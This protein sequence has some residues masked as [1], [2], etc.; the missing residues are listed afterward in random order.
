MK[1]QDH[2][3]KTK[4]LLKRYGIRSFNKKTYFTISPDNHNRQKKS[5]ENIVFPLRDQSL[6]K[7]ILEN[8]M[9]PF[10][11]LTFV[12]A[13]VLVIIYFINREE[14]QH[15]LVFIF[16]SAIILFK[17]CFEVY[18]EVRINAF[19]KANIDSF[20]VRVIRNSKILEI[21]KKDLKVGDIL[22]LQKG[23]VV[24]ADSIL[25]SE[26]N[27][28][29]D[30]RSLTGKP[31]L[32]KKHAG[33]SKA[34]FEH[35]ENVVLNG[36]KV[37]TGRGKA[38]VVRIGKNTVLGKSYS[39]LSLR[40]INESILNTEIR[41]YFYGSMIFST[42]LSVL[43]IIPAVLYH[44]SFLNMLSLII[45]VYVAVIPE[46]IVSIAKLMLFSAISKLDQRGITIRDVNAIEKLGLLT[47]VL[48]EKQT[49]INLNCKICDYIY[50]GDSLIDIDL[51]FQDNDDKSLKSIEYFGR[52]SYLI[53][54]KTN[55]I[56]KPVHQASFKL[57]GELCNKYFVGVSRVSTK[58]KDKKI[59]NVIASIV[60]N[61]DFKSVYV[62][63][64]LDSVIK[65]CNK[66]RKDGKVQHL[67]REIKNKIYRNCQK[68]KLNGSDIIVMAGR[69]YKSDEPEIKLKGLIFECAFFFEE[70]P[71]VSIYASVEV[72]KASGIK[73]SILTDSIYESDLKSCKKVLGFEEKLLRDED[74]IK[75]SS[76]NQESII[77]A[78]RY[79]SK[80]L[81]ARNRTLCERSFLIYG[82][83]PD[84]KYEI[85]KNLQD[86]G[87]TVSYVGS[88][89]DDCKGLGQ[90]DFGVCFDD[91][92]QICKES[93]SIVLKS[94]KFENIIYGVEEGRLLLINLRKSIKYIIMH[95]TPQLLALA[96]F[97]FLGTPLPISPILLIFLNYTVEVLPSK[98]FSYEEP[99]FNL[100]IEPPLIRPS[101]IREI[102]HSII[103][104]E[105][106]NTQRPF[107]SEL[108]NNIARY[109]F[110]RSVYPL[111]DISWAMVLS[112]IISG[113]G[114]MMAFFIVLYESQ[115]P[116]S[117][118]FFVANKYFQY[119]SPGLRLRNNTTAYFERQLDILF[120][121]QSSF[122][123][124]LMICQLSN[125]LVCRR[126]KLYFFSKFFRN[127]KILLFSVLGVGI[128]IAVVVIGF[129]DEFLLV[130]KPSVLSLIAPLIAAL[131]IL[132]VDTLQKYKSKKPEMIE[133]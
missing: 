54:E 125:M 45:S 36:D 69:G 35:A 106:Q 88:N 95:I 68:M 120:T 58:I 78:E 44:T 67:S 49:I 5:L 81:S 57:F 94:N 107:I 59:H 116:V 6:S 129:F 72:L 66:Y 18:Q 83:E 12:G 47:I 23:D 112:S 115:V 50:D 101:E 2:E 119:D 20:P 13:T 84:H 82:C 27:L 70:E 4:S 32:I 118:M 103:L 123:V 117:K 71:D 85:V 8:L 90:A 39:K 29:V 11:V 42:V 86:L 122:F 46:G 97:S 96:F 9:E 133:Q 15:L 124:G 43:F 30:D 104:G 25:I 16:T 62:T 37:I 22:D 19:Y 63:G 89:I 56:Y 100:M 109:L 75:A 34:A 132:S 76:N 91:S 48:A 55:S 51:A 17:T 110:Q 10:N 40:R 127:I 31:G 74:L 99:E 108:Y 121:G 77:R 64:D 26:N 33:P 61:K 21:N 111:I 126:E 105:N 28:K 113:I 128:S 92:G 7:L 41:S 1:L 130:R 65:L 53:G 93:S 79:M 102:D 80:D 60:D 24:G 3:L 98:F 73:F 38:L 131:L 14:K 52:I 87:D 114:C